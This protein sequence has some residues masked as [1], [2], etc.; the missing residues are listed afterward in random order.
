M[1]LMTIIS[2]AF[3]HFLSPGLTR[4]F[5]TGALVVTPYLLLGRGLLASRNIGKR[6]YRFA[7]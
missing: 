5:V 6:T 7:E 1:A 3:W 4:W 2:A